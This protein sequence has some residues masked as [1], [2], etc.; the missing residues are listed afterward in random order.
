MLNQ[1]TKIIIGAG[2]LLSSAAIIV[3]VFFP[4]E[5]QETGTPKEIAQ[6]NQTVQLDEKVQDNATTKNNQPNDLNANNLNDFDNQVFDENGE[7]L[8]Y[9][10]LLDEDINNEGPQK[11]DKASS[12]LEV[13]FE[14]PI[15]EEKYVKNPTVTG[16]TPADAA[17][18]QALMDEQRQREKELRL[19]QEKKQ[20]Q[21]RAQKQ[22]EAR[23]KALEEK[24]R[25]EA[26]KKED[27]Q[28]AKL[29]AKKKEDERKAK[30]EQ[31]I[32]QLKDEQNKKE[33]TKVEPKNLGSTNVQA[34]KVTSLSGNTNTNN[35]KI[36]TNQTLKQIQCGAYSDKNKAESVK[37]KL[38]AK[39]LKS[40]SGA[41]IPSGAYRVKQENG[42][43]KVYVGP[44]KESGVQ[45]LLSQTK[46]VN[47]TCVVK[48]L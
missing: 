5:E 25:L 23:R 13:G 21:E 7:D 31:R 37:V 17:S 27:E 19:A 16:N 48:D 3:P 44:I 32:K 1:F 28:K 4:G 22:D 24:A 42:L 47:I 38:M 40:S 30:E 15:E 34:G 2:V 41:P 6:I 11:E 39:G 36:K 33:L 18:E 12:G 43:F 10:N 14:D 20:A 45:N 26:K 9:G 29:E 46:K 8:G 35:Q